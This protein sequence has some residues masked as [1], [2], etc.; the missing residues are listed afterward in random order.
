MFTF[1]KYHPQRVCG[2]WRNFPVEYVNMIR[3]VDTEH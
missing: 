3:P 1:A 2:D